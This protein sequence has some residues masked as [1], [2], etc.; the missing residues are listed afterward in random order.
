MTTITKPNSIKGVH[1]LPREGKWVVRRS[2]KENAISLSATRDEAVKKGKMIA[3]SNSTDFYLH[4][5]TGR[6]VSRETYY[7]S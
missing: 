6:I 5:R 7:K 3:R 4:D 1:V 2:G